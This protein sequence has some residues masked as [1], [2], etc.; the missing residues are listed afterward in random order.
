MQ[1]DTLMVG[2]GEPMYYEQGFR[3]VLE[4][5]LNF[6]VTHPQTVARQVDSSLA[7]RY[8]YDFYGLLQFYGVPE[9]LHWLHMRM[10]NMTNPMQMTRGLTYFLVPNPDIVER[11]RSNYSMSR[12][13]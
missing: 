3:N 11:L 4:D 13:T 6:L 7:Y 10:M 9:H 2:T 8:E 1:V 12:Q 5:H